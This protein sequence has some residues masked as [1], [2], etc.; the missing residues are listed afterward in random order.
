[1]TTEEARAELLLHELTPEQADAV[2]DLAVECGQVA[3][4]SPSTGETVTVCGDDDA[5]VF[6]LV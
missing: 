4:T 5:Q 1:M 6:R 3:F 2:L